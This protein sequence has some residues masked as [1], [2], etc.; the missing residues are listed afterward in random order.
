MFLRVSA[1]SL[2][3]ACCGAVVRTVTEMCVCCGAV[4]R[5][6]G[7]RRRTAEMTN[8]ES[9]IRDMLCTHACCAVRG[10][11]RAVSHARR[12]WTFATYSEYARTH[13][14]TS[15]DGTPNPRRRRRCR[16]ESSNFDGEVV[17]CMRYVA[18]D[19]MRI[20]RYN[21]LRR[22]MWGRSWGRDERMLRV[23]QEASFS[24][25][26]TLVRVRG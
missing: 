17:C 13:I 19:D 10:D 21:I 1:R 5:L 16:L 26:P 15:D 18:S 7:D 6:V 8:E 4:R 22:C 11:V 3:C 20:S 24:A 2:W 9:S 12:R 25:C 14:C 23:V